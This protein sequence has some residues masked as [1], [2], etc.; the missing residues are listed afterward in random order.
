LSGLDRE[1]GSFG[2]ERAKA[3]LAR[4]CFWQAGLCAFRGWGARSCRR[5]RASTLVWWQPQK[6]DRGKSRISPNGW[7]PP[8]VIGL[9]SWPGRPGSNR[10]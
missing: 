1:D 6:R 9:P 10:I 7:V 5:E 8:M 4:R 3:G 2:E